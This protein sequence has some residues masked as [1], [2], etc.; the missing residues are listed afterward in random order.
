MIIDTTITLEPQAIMDSP[1]VSVPL[2]VVGETS[3]KMSCDKADWRVC[4]VKADGYRTLVSCHPRH[5]SLLDTALDVLDTL[6]ARRRDEDA[7]R[8]SHQL[9]TAQENVTL[10]A[11]LLRMVV[12]YSLDS[13][14]PK[15]FPGWVTVHD[16]L[17]TQFHNFLEPDGYNVRHATSRPKLRGAQPWREV[18]FYTLCSTIQIESTNQP[19]QIG[20]SMVGYVGRIRACRLRIK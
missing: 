8:R 15:L 12:Q 3:S 5:T 7:Q 1:V 10:A 13:R 20:V 14:F 6:Q 17:R 19:E 9:S 11:S 16:L 2:V 18:C 4:I